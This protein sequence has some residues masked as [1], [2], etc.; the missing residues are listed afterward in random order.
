MT[1][2]TPNATDLNAL[3]GPGLGAAPAGLRARGEVGHVPARGTR[4]LITRAHLDLQSLVRV[5]EVWSHRSL[6]L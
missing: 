6:L 3:H 2:M 1:I 4:V 5:T